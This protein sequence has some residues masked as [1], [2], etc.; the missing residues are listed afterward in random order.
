MW[1][2]YKKQKQDLFL[3]HDGKSTARFILI[4]KS[5]APFGFLLSWC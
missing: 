1:L 4:V 2:I 3:S 5:T